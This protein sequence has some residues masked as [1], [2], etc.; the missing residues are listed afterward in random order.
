MRGL[1]LLIQ[2]RLVLHLPTLNV[3]NLKDKI[4]NKAH[5]LL[6]VV[7]FA[8]DFVDVT[9]LIN[10]IHN[11]LQLVVTPRHLKSNILKLKLR[12]M[13]CRILLCYLSFLYKAFAHF[14]SCFFV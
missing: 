1:I 10:S 5:F 11:I 2:M 6:L 13:R 8:E 3:L 4:V 12:V 7:G 14:F 9:L